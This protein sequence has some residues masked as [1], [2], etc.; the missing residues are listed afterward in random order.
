MINVSDK[1]RRGNQNTRF[2]F[3]NSFENRAV[4][5]MWKNIV[6]PGW[7]QIKSMMHAHCILDT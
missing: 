3:S 5:E 7:S 2:T 1:S 6:E 4:Y